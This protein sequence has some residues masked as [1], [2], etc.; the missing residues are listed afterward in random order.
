MAEEA[1]EKVM[2][3]VVEEGSRRW[4]QQKVV[5]EVRKCRR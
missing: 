1:A 3:E 2:K 4:H 5:E